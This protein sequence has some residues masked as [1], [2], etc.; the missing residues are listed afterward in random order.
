MIF[1]YDTDGK[2]IKSINW[3]SVGQNADIE[4][5]PKLGNHIDDTIQVSKKDAIWLYN[6]LPKDV[7]LRIY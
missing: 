2:D 1:H 4:A 6:N 3:L 7:Q 5:E